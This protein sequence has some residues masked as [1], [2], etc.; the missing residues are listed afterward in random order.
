MMGIGLRNL[1]RAFK[2]DPCGKNQHRQHC[3]N[4]TMGFGFVYMWIFIKDLSRTY[5][6]IM[7]GF[8]PRTKFIITGK[9]CEL[10]H[11]LSN[12]ERVLSKSLGFGVRLTWLHHLRPAYVNLAIILW[13]QFSNPQNGVTVCIQQGLYENQMKSCVKCLAHCLTHHTRWIRVP[14]IPT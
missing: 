9:L 1:R 6:I 14:P 11:F 2:T 12:C 8:G 4:I 5:V 10:T 13:P 3:A 7:N